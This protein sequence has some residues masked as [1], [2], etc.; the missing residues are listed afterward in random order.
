VNIEFRLASKIDKASI[1]RFYKQQ[2]YSAGFM[3]LDHT[4]L[5]LVNDAIIGAVIVSKIEESNSQYLLHGLVVAQQYRGQQ[6]AS[7]LI[8]HMT[9]RF[10][11]IYCFADSSLQNFY[12]NNGAALSSEDNLSTTL[13]NRLNA[14]LKH[15]PKLN[16]FHLS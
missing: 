12:L 7:S 10:T 15:S 2:K 6:I 1:K 8:K 14:Y 16:V 5:A 11:S 3:G 13:A 4:M 9:K